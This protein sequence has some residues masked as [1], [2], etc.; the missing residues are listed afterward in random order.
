M[1]EEGMLTNQHNNYATRKS[2]PYW[3]ALA[4]SKACFMQTLRCEAHQRRL[5]LFGSTHEGQQMMHE[6]LK[7][8]R[9]RPVSRLK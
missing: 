3:W 7:K 5:F 1:L 9:Y 4:Y 6:G 8:G 2:V